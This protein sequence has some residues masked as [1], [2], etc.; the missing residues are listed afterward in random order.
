M[1]NLG[2]YIMV[3]CNNFAYVVTESFFIVNGKVI[4]N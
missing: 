3:V 2:I 1:I 4:L